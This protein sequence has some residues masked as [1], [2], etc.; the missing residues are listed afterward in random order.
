VSDV[1][2]LPRRL[3]SGYPVKLLNSMSAAKPVV[4]AGCGSKVLTHG[5]DAIVVGDDDP[6]ALAS[7]LDLLRRDDARREALG[8]AARRTFLEE[9]TWERV[10]PRIEEVY[11]GLRETA[12]PGRGSGT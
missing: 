1:V 10:L 7:A 8:R 9:R 4:S 2:A 5:V 12:P 3:G 11:A 6:G